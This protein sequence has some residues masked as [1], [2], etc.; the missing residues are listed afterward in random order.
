M[1]LILVTLNMLEQSGDASEGALNL[2]ESAN[3]VNIS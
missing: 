1:Q 2:M 3:E